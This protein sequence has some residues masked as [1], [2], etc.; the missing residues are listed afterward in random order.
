M[1]LPIQKEK[2]EAEICCRWIGEALRTDMRVMGPLV[3][4]EVAAALV[5]VLALW[6][7]SW[8][9]LARARAGRRRKA[10]ECILVVMRL[11]VSLVGVCEKLEGDS[12][13][14]EDEMLEICDGE[15]KTVLKKRQKE[16]FILNL[17]PKTILK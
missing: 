17:V 4:V 2:P 1:F 6:V 7:E 10:R 9:G 5:V 11:G 14:F 12:K 16:I 15:G 8:I 3:G 13:D